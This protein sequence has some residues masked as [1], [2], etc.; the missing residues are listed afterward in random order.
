MEKVEFKIPY[1]KFGTIFADK[2]GDNL[3]ITGV[4]KDYYKKNIWAPV[5]K[6]FNLWKYY[7][8]FAIYQQGKKFMGLGIDKEHNL[9]EVNFSKRPNRYIIEDE[10]PENSTWYF[11]GLATYNVDKILSQGKDVIKRTEEEARIRAE[12]LLHKNANENRAKCGA[13]ERHIERWDEGNWNGVVYDHGFE[14][15]GYRAGVCIGARYQPWEKSSDGKIAYIKQL[16]DREA[17]ILGS[18]P[19]QAKLD[20]MIKASDEYVVWNNELKKLKEDLWQDFRRSPWYPYK[21]LDINFRRY[22]VE[23]GHEKFEVPKRN[24]QFFGVHVWNQ[25]TLDE[26]LNVWQRQLDMIRNIISK[27]QSK[28]DNWQEQLTAR[29]I[30]N[31]RG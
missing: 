25:T 18:K 5:H 10:K 27:E 3:V 28:V 22:L 21:N 8:D 15:A 29:E 7:S 20:K 23:Q 16:R 14:Q 12:K 2:D 1:T 31:S 9:V 24:P 11:Y 26:L 13:C 17:I 19:N 4:S 6:D 30:I